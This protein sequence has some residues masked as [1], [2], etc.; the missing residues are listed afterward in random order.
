MKRILIEHARNRPGVVK[1]PLEG[2]EATEETEGVDIET[3]EVALENL[4]RIDGRLR[5]VVELRFFGGMQFQE[6]AEVLEIN[7]RTARRDWK[8]AR[9]LLFE[10]L[11]GSEK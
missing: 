11:G 8:V 9:A 5:S 3:I 4:E 6:I 7:A 10:A 2:D 1:V